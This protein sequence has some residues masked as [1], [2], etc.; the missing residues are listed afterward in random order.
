[1][2]TQPIPPVPGRPQANPKKELS[3]ISQI[4]LIV[5]TLLVMCGAFITGIVIVSNDNKTA[6]LGIVGPTQ[7]ATWPH[8]IPIGVTL[9][10]LQ[11]YI[12]S[13]S[14]VTTM[15]RQIYAAKHSWHANTVRFQV[16]QDRMVGA[17]G[18]HF[19]RYY[20]RD[21]QEVTRY[22]LH[23]HLR[24]VINAQTEL[25]MGYALSESLPTHA[26]TVFWDKVLHHYKN[27][28]RVILDLFNEPR[29]CNWEQWQ[30][31]FQTLINHI[32]GEG[33][34]NQIWVEGINWGSTLEDVP[35]LHGGNIVYTFHH[36]GAPWPNQ[37]PVNKATWNKA[38][39]YLAKE[40]I[41]VVDAEFSNF[42]GSYDWQAPYI[43]H[44]HQPGK[45]VRDYLAYLRH[46]NIGMLAWSLLAGSLNRDQHYDSVTVEPQGDGT[47]VHD[48]FK[49]IHDKNK[50]GNQ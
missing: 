50:K 8:G 6:D 36:P 10:G 33:V 35:L 42:V 21:L 30:Y 32:R 9:S 49:R 16:L 29:R 44:G 17:D 37:A 40:G 18:H 19:E 28:R 7:H 1:M 2:T 41:P 5:M 4:G 46:N 20:M 14:T 43:R 45:L 12:L 25:S 3:K 22:A 31:A 47:L 34:T 11:Q 23:Q 48:W 15:E 13:Q 24:V 39:G 26:T 38:F 27:N